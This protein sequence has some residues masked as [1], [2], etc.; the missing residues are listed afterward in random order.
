MGGADGRLA[1]LDAGVLG[2]R[3][4]EHDHAGGC[5]LD[6]AGD[7]LADAFDRIE[8][9]LLGLRQI[10]LAPFTRKIIGQG[11][12]ALAALMLW[13]GQLVWFRWNGQVH[14][15]GEQLG[16]SG[17]LLARRTEVHAPQIEELLFERFNLCAQ[18]RDH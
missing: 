8:F 2:A 16:L 9:G 11:R 5:V 15:L 7:F 17:E 12:T 10:V 4:F 13:N 18:I 3:M 14:L 1:I 6:A